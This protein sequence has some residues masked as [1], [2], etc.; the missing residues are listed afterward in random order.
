[1]SFKNS[2]T[3]QGS[4][5]FQNQKDNTS[6]ADFNLD[7]DRRDK[8]KETKKFLFK[9]E[10]KDKGYS[11]LAG[12]VNQDSVF[13]VN[14]KN[15]K[16]TKADVKKSSLSVFKKS[17]KDEKRLKDIK[18]T[19]EEPKRSKTKVKPSDTQKENLFGNYLEN[20]VSSFLA[21]DNVRVPYPI[22]ICIDIIEQKG[23]DNESIYRHHA[24]KSQLESICESINNESME[25]RLDELNADPNLACAVIKKF[26]KE[27]KSPIVPD[28]NLVFIDKCESSDR[29][30]K[31]HQLKVAI[32]KFP[33]SNFDTF[34]YLIMHFHRVLSK[35]E[36]NKI[37]MSIFVQKFQPIFRIKERIFKF[38][39]NNASALFK[40]YRFKK[41]KVKSNL[42]D[43]VSRVSHLPE[44]IEDLEQEIARQEIYLSKLHSRIAS[45]E[46]SNDKSVQ[47]Q[48]SEELWGLQRYV[49]SLK[50]KVKKLKSE[51]KNIEAEQI[52]NMNKNKSD[53]SKAQNQPGDENKDV[54][55]QVDKEKETHDIKE[56]EAKET[57]LIC[58]NS[59]WIES[60]Q[61][62]IEKISKE[63]M[64]ISDLQTNLSSSF[65]NTNFILPIPYTSQFP[66]QELYDNE[67]LLLNENK[68]LEE[69]I[70]LINKRINAEKDKIFELKLSIKLKAFEN[71]T[72]EYQQ[73]SNIISSQDKDLVMT[74][75]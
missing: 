32:T 74:K 58:E 68:L 1:M 27:L 11:S 20:A 67:Q 26:L 12:D 69:R 36:T 14:T 70:N 21:N 51:R 35:S 15:S 17:F 71:S 42:E 57:N 53:E 48:L 38:I 43:T 9:K 16:K 46:H 22:R 75:L 73:Q 7:D 18:E 8:K 66:L 23:I 41:Y 34:A 52:K 50:R 33:Q 4:D 54:N 56:L 59:V 49:T 6:E 13:L 5:D 61:Q 64:L 40:D 28:E 60:L 10:T 19:K 3:S 39:I 44:S 2:N 72:L 25:T 65:A 30:Q 24:N 29:D 63:Q 62:L 31:I 47:D 45:E 37:E 55:G